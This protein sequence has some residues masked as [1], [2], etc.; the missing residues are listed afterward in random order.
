MHRSLP[1]CAL[2]FVCTFIWPCPLAR[3]PVKLRHS[4]KH[5][6]A[7]TFKEVSSLPVYRHKFDE[8]GWRVVRISRPRPPLEKEQFALF[9][10]MV[11]DKYIFFFALPKYQ[12]INMC[13]TVA[14]K[15]DARGFLWGETQRKFVVSG[16]FFLWR[17][18]ESE[19]TR[20][21]S[22]VG[23]VGRWRLW[24]LIRFYVDTPPV[25]VDGV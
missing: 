17:G 13:V 16:Y 1:T 9:I 24:L 18:W 25:P 3:D 12:K 5:L 14:E 6:L 15:K 7:S 2:C 4:S 20:E 22:W 8:C 19:I 21:S 11:I 10:V 23:G